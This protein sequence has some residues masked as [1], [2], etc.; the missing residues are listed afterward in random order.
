MIFTI[1]Y[2]SNPVVTLSSVVCLSSVCQ[3]VMSH[4]HALVLLQSLCHAVTVLPFTFVPSSHF[5]LFCCPPMALSRTG[6][7]LVTQSLSRNHH[8]VTG[9]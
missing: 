3:T 2:I 8:R 4:S 1:I 7:A 6:T 5:V 9:Q